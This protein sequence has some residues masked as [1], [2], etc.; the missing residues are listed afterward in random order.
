MNHLKRKTMNTLS[1][2]QQSFSDKVISMLYAMENDFVI[3]DKVRPENIDKFIEVVK[4]PIDSKTTKFI[5][6]FSTD[7]KRLRKIKTT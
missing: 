4:W 3:A 5:I 2:Y 6:E 7:Y 1:N